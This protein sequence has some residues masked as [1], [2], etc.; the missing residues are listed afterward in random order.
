MR[1]LLT[2]EFITNEGKRS[3]KTTETSNTKRKKGDVR[4]LKASLKST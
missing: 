3:S 1:S 2:P 4:M